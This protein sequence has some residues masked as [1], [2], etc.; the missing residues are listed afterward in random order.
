MKR[1]G[2]YRKLWLAVVISAALPFGFGSCGA[3]SEPGVPPYS[4]PREEAETIILSDD[5]IVFT[6]SGIAAAENTVTISEGG[7]YILTGT[8]SDGKIIVDTRNDIYIILDS[9]D[10]TSARSSALDFVNTGAAVIELAGGTVNRLSDGEERVRNSDEDGDT[11]AVIYSNAAI[12]LA[13]SGALYLSGT[14]RGGIHSNRTVDIYSGT[15]S[16]SVRN[17]GVFAQFRLTVHG[18]EITVEQ[19]REGMESNGELIINSGNIRITARDDALNAGTNLV[20]NGGHIYAESDGDGFDSN[21]DMTVNGGELYIFAGS[22]KNSAL[23]ISNGDK[24]GKFT[25]NGGTVVAAGGDNR[26]DIE[27]QSKQGYAW[28]YPQGQF[29]NGDMASVVSENGEEIISFAFPKEFDLLF[30]STDKIKPNGK[31]LLAD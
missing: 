23:D 15:L 22:K 26:V 30:V 2:K 6:G 19:S 11:N 13:G 1:I 8:L 16:I 9:V 4:I 7:S 20:I 21:G 29:K 3:A 5:N 18:G 28:I 12:T 31:Y 24:I 17:Q 14:S 27:A 10:I 25:I